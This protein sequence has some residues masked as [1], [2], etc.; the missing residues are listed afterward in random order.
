MPC[1]IE[2]TTHHPPTYPAASSPPAS[3]GSSGCLPGLQPQFRHNIRHSTARTDQHDMSSGAILGIDHAA[4]P[5]GGRR[6]C[7]K[8]AGG[9]GETDV[10]V[11]VQIVC[12]L[13]ASSCDVHSG[14]QVSTYLDDGQGGHTGQGGERSA[15]TA[16]GGV[17]SMY[18]GVP[19]MY[20]SC[21][22]IHVQYAWS[23]REL[24][25]AGPP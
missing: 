1:R 14:R 25:I 5:D 16:A 15:E 22:A 12:N 4:R 13:L 10:E 3:P 9:N 21:T 17:P 23:A 8:R 24:P 19:S 7:R 18:G 11:I 2:S 20:V 6:R